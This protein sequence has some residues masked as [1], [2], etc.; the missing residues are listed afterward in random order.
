MIRK[1][2]F[3]LLALTLL[4]WAAGCSDSTT[5]PIADGE[6]NLDSE[7]GGY[8]ANAENPGFD[9]SDLIA[10]AAADE[11]FD[12]PMLCAPEVVECLAD[13]DAGY[14]HIRAVWGRLCYDSAV[15]DVTDWTGSLTI[16]RGVE[17]I[18][19]VIRFEPRQDFILER[20]DPTLIEWQSLTTVHND[21]IAVDLFVPRP[22]PTFDTTLTP[23]VDSLG[24]TAWVAV[25]DTVYPELEP[26]TLAFE[27]GPYSRVF[28]MEELI[29]LDTVVLLDDSN[30]VAFHALK[31]DHRP[32]PRGFLAGK[33][34]YNEE[35]EGVFRGTWLTKRGRI[36]GYLRGHFGENSDGLKVF[37]GKWITTSGKFEGFLKGICG[38]HPN[39]RAN[40]QAFRRGTG[41]FAGGIFNANGGEIGVLKGRFGSTPDDSGGFFQGRWKLRCNDANVEAS[42]EDEGF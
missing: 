27:T 15:T 3:P 33:W 1:L 21:G 23:E 31:L 39:E 10:E 12:D 32:C 35:G 6:L 40:G 30:V 29:G 25:I 38:W 22:C 19:R 37:F 24:D 18:R 14:Y 2:A 34:G 36:N 41:W 20:T 26:V 42:D 16:S 5:E 13:P 7:F 11:E 17:I 28:S 8:T 4:I 9:E